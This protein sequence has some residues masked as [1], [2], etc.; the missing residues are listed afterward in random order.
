MLWKSISNRVDLHEIYG[1][2]ATLLTEINEQWPIFLQHSYCNREQRAIINK[3]QLKSND[4]SFVVVQ[5]DFSENYI[6]ARQREVQ[7]THWNNNQAT[8]FT[9]HIKAGQSH[10]NMVIISDYMYHNTAFVYCAQ[11]LIVEFVKNNFPQVQ[12]MSYVR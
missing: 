4:Q 3:I 10:K 11:G 5:I 8:V 1:S 9:V 6:F 7:A 2:I 12:K